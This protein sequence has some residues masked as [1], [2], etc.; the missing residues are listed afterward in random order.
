MIVAR[1]PFRISFTGGGTDLRAFYSGRPGAV[2]SSAINRYMYVMV[3]KRFDETVR[4]SYTQTEI[5]PTVDDVQHEL[6]REAMRLVGIA[7]A[8]EITT[9][10]DVPAGTG[11]GS[12]SSLTVGLLHALFAFQSRYRSPEQLARDA[13]LIET[14]VLGRPIGKQDQYAAAYGGLNYVQFHADES[15]FV[16]PIVC[17]AGTR[18][19]LERRLQMFYLGARRNDSGILHEQKRRTLENAGTRDLLQCMAGLAGQTRD[20][21]QNNDLDAFGALLEENWQLKKRANPGVS[22]PQIDRWHEQA[23]DAGAIGGKVLGA[24]G[25]GFLLFFCRAGSQDSL[26]E[27]MEESEL[28]YFPVQLEP[29][30]SKVILIS[31]GQ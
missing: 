19:E 29:E 28:R 11:L 23:L 18:R 21:L 16:E 14:E 10:A 8:V 31:D 3:N 7:N 17:A 6:V 2:V 1:T 20:A 26:R 12:S 30:G 4:V 24:G 9:V 5:V 22:N 13:C 27:A 25:A 15:V